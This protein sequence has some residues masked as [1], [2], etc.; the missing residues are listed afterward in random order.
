MTTYQLAIFDLDGTLLNTISDLGCACNH[1]LSQ[2]GYPLHTP[3]EYPHLVGNGVNR[4]IMRALPAEARTEDNVL[5]LRQVFIPYYNTHNKVHTRPYQGITHVLQ[6]LKRQGW[7]L[8][9][10]SNK[11]QAATED[12]IR[13]YFPGLFDVVLGEREGCPRK[14]DPQIVRDIEEIIKTAA[15]KEEQPTTVAENLIAADSRTDRPTLHN[16]P[17]AFDFEQSALSS[18]IYIGDSD[19]DMQ[20][21]KN[22]DVP[23]VACTWGFCPRETLLTY[24]PPFVADKPKDILTIIK[25][26]QQ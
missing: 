20:T 2:F 6:E 18:V 21:A 4:L 13:H 1:A 11:Y 19:V 17:S 23:A 5:R 14:P 24:N 3:E 22:A 25:T 15:L 26:M 7:L 8:A 12:L 9:V 10:A 16:R